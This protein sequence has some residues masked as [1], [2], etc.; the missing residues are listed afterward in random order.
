[1]FLHEVSLDAENKIIFFQKIILFS[2]GGELRSFKFGLR[3]FKFKFK[4]SKKSQTNRNIS[5]SEKS[6]LFE[7]NIFSTN[8]PEKDKK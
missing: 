7:K 2:R 1:M 8:V 4:N 5:L 6:Q 3:I